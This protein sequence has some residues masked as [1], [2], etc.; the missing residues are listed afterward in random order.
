M[1]KGKRIRWVGR[2]AGENMTK[3]STMPMVRALLVMGLAGAVGCR[4]AVADPTPAEAEFFE[5]KVRPLLAARCYGCHG[6]EAVEKGKLKAGLR[7]DSREAMEKGGE[8][9]AVLAQRCWT[10]L[11]RG[12]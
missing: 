3:L 5:A 10:R 12:R 1:S 8:S 2:P 7:L 4:V 11:G 6:A 9:G